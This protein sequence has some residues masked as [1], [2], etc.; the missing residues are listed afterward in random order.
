M[1][2]PSTL[3]SCRSNA[4]GDIAWRASGRPGFP[5]HEAQARLL[6]AEANSQFAEAA[7]L[8]FLTLDYAREAGEATA[9][10]IAAQMPGA[11]TD[12]LETA[13]RECEE[14]DEC[15]SPVIAHLRE[16]IRRARERPP[17]SS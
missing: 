9:A 13:L 8:S 10:L 6:D 12:V 5:I 15:C 1:S 7:E 2:P 11:S 4:A 17:D 3:A 14:A 16:R